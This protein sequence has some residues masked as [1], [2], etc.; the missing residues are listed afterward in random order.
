MFKDDT[1]EPVFKQAIEA[2]RSIHTIEAS[3]HESKSE[4]VSRERAD[5]PHKSVSSRSGIEESPK[6][7]IKNQRKSNKSGV[8]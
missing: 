3:Q 4:N 8:R 1:P 6:R 7:I 2:T 5:T